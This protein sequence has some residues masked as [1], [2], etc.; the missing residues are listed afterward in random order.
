MPQAFPHQRYRCCMA[1]LS[2]K[3]KTARRAALDGLDVKEVSSITPDIDVVVIVRVTI[4]TVNVV[5]CT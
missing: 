5:S 1:K 4:V 2:T 3:P